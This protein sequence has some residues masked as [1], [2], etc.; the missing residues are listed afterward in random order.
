MS[1]L[2]LPFILNSVPQALYI[3]IGRPQRFGSILPLSLLFSRIVPR[4]ANDRIARIVR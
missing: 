4:I 1:Q 3:T 2:R